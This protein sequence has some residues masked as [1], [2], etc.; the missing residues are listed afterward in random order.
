MRHIAL[1]A[2]SFLL[3]GPQAHAGITIHFKGSASDG[4]AFLLLGP[5]A[6]AG[7]TIHFKGSASDGQAV[8][9]IAEKACAL[10]KSNQWSCE[11]LSGE[12]I[13]K[14]DGITA[15]FIVENEKSP[16]LA[17]AKG[18]VIRPHEMSE[19]LYLV[20]GTSGRIQNF[21]KTQFAGAE[22]HIKVVELLE[23]LKPFFTSLEFED[24]GGYAQTKDK[25]RLAREMEGVDV[26]IAKIK[27]DRPD[28]QGPVKRPDG[29][30]LDL[31]S[32]K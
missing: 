4:Q 14:A 8:E 25:Q 17:G 13:R 3:L 5:Q 24:E 9:R 11:Q 18:V 20:F 22:I 23:Q 29:R 21:V 31:V 10:A 28:A 32:K 12:D 27:R 1:F 2:L 19:P 7:I 30:I 16:D 26:M 15:K 6:H